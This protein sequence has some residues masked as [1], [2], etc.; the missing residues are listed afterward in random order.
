MSAALLEEFIPSYDFSER[1]SVTVAASREACREAIQTW[2]PDSSAPW[3][4]LLRLRGLGKPAGTLR[5][6]AEYN[7][8]LLLAETE[9]EVAYGQIGRFWALNERGALASPRTTEEFLA[10]DRPGYAVAVMN[11][12]TRPL[13]DGRTRISTETRIRAL[14]AGARRRFRLY[15]LLIRPFSGFLRREMLKGF[16]AVARNRHGSQRIGKEAVV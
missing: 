7:G 6:W 8:F 15:W 10:F 2:R 5:E 13:N 12:R 4:F 11:V 16:A 3:R 1:H 9:D 14:S